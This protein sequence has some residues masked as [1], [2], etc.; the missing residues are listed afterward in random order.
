MDVFRGWACRQR[1]LPTQRAGKPGY[2]MDR[3]ATVVGW[4]GASPG[5]PWRRRAQWDARVKGQ[6]V[7]ALAGVVRA[8]RSVPTR[9]L[10]LV[11]QSGAG[12][13]RAGRGPRAASNQGGHCG[14]HVGR[15]PSYK[16]GIAMLD[17]ADPN[18]CDMTAG[19][20]LSMVPAAGATSG[21]LWPTTRPW[22]WVCIKLFVARPL[23]RLPAS[24]ACCLRR[25]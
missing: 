14:P 9:G 3:C 21:P 18:A 20:P 7:Q 11:D 13:L 12:A 23:T 10:G 8:I 19:Y 22:P 5:S 15:T 2:L 1:V 17:A 6:G 24:R 4:G 25:H 16:A